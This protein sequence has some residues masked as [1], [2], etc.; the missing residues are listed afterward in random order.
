MNIQEVPNQVQYPYEKDLR[1]KLEPILVPI[2]RSAI[3]VAFG[4]VLSMI[5]IG[6]AWSLYIFFGASSI[7]TWKACLFFGSGFG[8]GTGAFAAWLHLDRETSK[9]LLLTAAAVLGGGILGS[10]GGLLYGEAQDIECCAE[11]TVSPVYYTALGSAVVAN[12]AG[13]VVAT[14]RAIANRKRRTQFPNAVH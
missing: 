10:W 3:G 8:A 4:V 12:I 5:G 7:D 13:I 9:V 1:E 6:V 2:A 14:I 11:P